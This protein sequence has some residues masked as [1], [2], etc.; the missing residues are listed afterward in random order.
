MCNDTQKLQKTH[1]VTKKKL[2]GFRECKREYKLEFND[3]AR[4][5][6]PLHVRVIRYSLDS[7]DKLEPLFGFEDDNRSRSSLAVES[8]QLDTLL[9]NP[10]SRNNIISR[11]LSGG[12]KSGS[13]FDNIFLSELRKFTAKSAL[14]ELLSVPF[15]DT[16][17]R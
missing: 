17:E 12:K 1:Q 3:C 15:S 13:R 9:R 16:F 7:M 6:D 5:V 4:P 14:F 8:T 11:S 10:Q 2:L